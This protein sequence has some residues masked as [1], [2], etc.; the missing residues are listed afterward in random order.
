MQI[1]LFARF[2]SRKIYDPSAAM[3]KL[4]IYSDIQVLDFEP[5][6]LTFSIDSGKSDSEQNA[7][8]ILVH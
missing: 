1:S 5:A 6:G 2:S 7:S 4:L 3:H 8:K